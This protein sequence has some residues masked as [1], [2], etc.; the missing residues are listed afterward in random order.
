MADATESY[1]PVEIIDAAD[2]EPI[3]ILKEQAALLGGRTKNAVEA[4]VKTSTEDGI[5]TIPCTSRPTHSEIT[6]TS[7]SRSPTR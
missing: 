7:S 4:V 5:R 2:P 1:W 3:A 6:S